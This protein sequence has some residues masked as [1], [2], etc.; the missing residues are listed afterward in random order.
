MASALH[1]HIGL[2]CTAK[3]LKAAYLRT[4]PIK[5]IRFVIVIFNCKYQYYVVYQ[6]V[7]PWFQW[8]NILEAG[9]SWTS[10]MGRVS[11]SARPHAQRLN[12]WK[13]G[14]HKE[15]INRFGCLESDILTQLTIRWGLW[16][17]RDLGYP[18]FRDNAMQMVQVVQ[19][20]P[21][22]KELTHKKEHIGRTAAYRPSKLTSHFVSFGAWIK[23]SK[24]HGETGSWFLFCLWWKPRSWPVFLA[25]L[26]ET[27]MRNDRCVLLAVLFIGDFPG[28]LISLLQLCIENVGTALRF[29]QLVCFFVS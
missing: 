20:K 24:C 4:S 23:L 7:S 1:C 18:F 11:P 14:I 12:V 19:A 27:A 2:T 10:P 5:L 26:R 21:V 13:W 25:A 6:R 28:A 29:P 22:S 17:T 3:P 15:L 8:L 9:T 16:S